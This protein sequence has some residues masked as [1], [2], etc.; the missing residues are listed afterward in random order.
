MELV[1]VLTAVGHSRS[2]AALSLSG[3]I[4]TVGSGEPQT[5]ERDKKKG[6]SYRLFNLVEYLK[7]GGGEAAQP[8]EPRELGKAKLAE[9]LSC[10]CPSALGQ[11]YL[12][13][14]MVKPSS[15]TLIMPC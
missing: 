15:E 10:W 2:T 3:L 14:L 11:Q 5:S 6:V 8:L 13:V 4:H 1:Q 7:L 12:G 9:D